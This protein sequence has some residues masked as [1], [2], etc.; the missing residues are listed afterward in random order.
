MSTLYHRHKSHENLTW[1]EVDYP[2][3]LQNKSSLSSSISTTGPSPYAPLHHVPCDLSLGTALTSLSSSGAVAEKPTL[4]ILEA[5]L[6]Y[7]S[8]SASTRLL[9]SLAAGY[10]EATVVVYDPVLDLGGRGRFGE[11]MRGHLSRAGVDCSGMDEFDT[12]ERQLGR[13]TS[14]GFTAST[15]LTMLELWRALPPSIRSR[16]EAAEMLDEME[17]WNMIMSHYVLLEGRNGGGGRAD[18]KP[19][20]ARDPPGT[21]RDGHDDLRSEAN[22]GVLIDR[23]E[24]QWKDSSYRVRE[25]D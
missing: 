2:S 17:E 14:C 12:L 18:R 15:G 24:A 23:T 21:Y 16:A 3:V 4:F 5:V 20:K 8:S 11:V 25:M 1:F 6:M 10:G 22:D 13:L 9:S 7:M 19:S